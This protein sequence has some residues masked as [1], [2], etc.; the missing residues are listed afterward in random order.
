MI[1]EENSS[2]KDIYV[3]YLKKVCGFVM[4]AYPWTLSKREAKRLKWLTHQSDGVMSLIIRLYLRKH[5][6]CSVEEGFNYYSFTRNTRKRQWT[7][8]VDTPPEVTMDR[9]FPK[10][11]NDIV[12]LCTEKKRNVSH[13]KNTEPSLKEFEF[14]RVGLSTRKFVLDTVNANNAFCLRML[15]LCGKKRDLVH[16]GKSLK[17]YDKTISLNQKW[18]VGIENFLSG[19]NT[20][21]QSSI[22]LSRHMK[23]HFL[24]LSVS[25]TWLLTK[26]FQTFYLGVLP[27]M[28]SQSFEHPVLMAM[29]G[30]LALPVYQ[31]VIAPQEYFHLDTTYDINYYIKVRYLLEIVYDL[32]DRFVPNKTPKFVQMKNQ[33]PRFKDLSSVYAQAEHE[34]EFILQETKATRNIQIEGVTELLQAVRAGNSQDAVGLM[35]C[36]CGL[37]AHETLTRKDFVTF[38]EMRNRKFPHLIVLEPSYFLTRLVY[39]SNKVLEKVNCYSLAFK[40]QIFLT[41][42]EDKDDLRWLSPIVATKLGKVF[43]RLFINYK[44][45][46]EKT[47]QSQEKLFVYLQRAINN[48]DFDDSCGEYLNIFKRYRQLGKILNKQVCSA[49]QVLF[50]ETNVRTINFDAMPLRQTIGNMY[51][52]SIF[53]CDD[54]DPDSFKT[55]F[56]VEEYALQ[57]YINEQE[58]NGIYCN[59]LHCE[60]SPL[61]MLFSLLLYDSF[62]SNE[63]NGCFPAYGQTLPLDLI[64][65]K[66]IPERWCKLQADLLSLFTLST[67][68]LLGTLECKYKSLVAPDVLQQNFYNLETLKLIAACIRNA[69]LPDLLIC[70]VSS[71]TGAANPNLFSDVC[72]SFGLRYDPD[73]SQNVNLSEAVLANLEL[74][75]IFAEVK[76]PNDRLNERQQLWLKYM[77]F[78]S[79]PCCEIKVT[80]EKRG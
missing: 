74:D 75:I 79:L 10:Q 30:K 50:L 43:V 2:G 27:S 52:K 14:D 6:A 53:V 40:F 38:S 65:S 45:V 67:W 77:D 59:G 72:P 7:A 68:D 33:V 48:K 51:G 9:F 32:F 66:I 13:I 1:K 8:M 78:N 3:R 23:R 15:R 22:A 70:S 47:D 25:V 63:M 61:R 29:F 31:P 39:I 41:N 54:L 69:G 35:L 60:G 37:Y 34:I 56:T 62:T 73:T 12:D 80:K 21:S 4:V 57:C 71:N 26:L 11:R 55:N 44:K 17:I 46:L 76:G 42:L 16:V 64:T 36:L 58:K 49:P 19:Q 28:K 18:L 5:N 24:Q 20:L